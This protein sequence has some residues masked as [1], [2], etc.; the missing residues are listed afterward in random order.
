MSLPEGSQPDNVT[1]L[2]EWLRGAYLSINRLDRDLHQLRDEVKHRLYALHVAEH[3]QLRERLDLFSALVEANEP[4]ETVTGDELI[5]EYE[6]FMAER[7]Q[8]Q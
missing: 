2:L 1:D 7:K 5:K 8:Q 6:A 3:P 4:I